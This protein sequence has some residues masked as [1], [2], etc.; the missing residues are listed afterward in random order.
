MYRSRL[1]RYALESSYD[2]VYLEYSLN[3]GTWSGTAG[4]TGLQRLGTPAGAVYRR[5]RAG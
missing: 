2:Y 4:A 1:V 5:L 3:G